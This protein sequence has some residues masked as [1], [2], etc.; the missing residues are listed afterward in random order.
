MPSFCQATSMTGVPETVHRNLALLP[1][2]VVIDSG[3]VRNVGGNAS[4][5]QRGSMLSRGEDQSLCFFSTFARDREQ[6][7]S[8]CH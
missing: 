1:T 2:K 6:E 5:K 3:L 4:A 7:G 8:V